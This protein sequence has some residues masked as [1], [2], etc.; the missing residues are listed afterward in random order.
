MLGDMLE[1]GDC[2]QSNHVEMGQ[3]VSESN[4]DM[5]ITVGELAGELAQGAMQAGM[6]EK[7]I[8]ISSDYHLLKKRLFVVL[9]F[10]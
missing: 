2:S 8:K 7:K 6:D 3:F 9:V 1:L 4:V 5:L 10:N